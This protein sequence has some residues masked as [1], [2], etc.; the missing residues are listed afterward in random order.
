MSFCQVEALTTLRRVRLLCECMHA[1]SD[2][3]HRRCRRRR[4]L[5]RTASC[6]PLSCSPVFEFNLC[7]PWSRSGGS[8]HG[9]GGPPSVPS[10]GLSVFPAAVFQLSLPPLIART[11]SNTRGSFQ[12]GTTPRQKTIVE[13]SV[14]HLIRNINL[15]SVYFKFDQLFRFISRQQQ[16][17]P[18]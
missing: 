14:Q 16:L 15:L 18:V 2:R 7:C 12:T 5:S 17:I 11:S 13:S 9:G 6:S 8:S 10:L 1:F 3:L 4:R